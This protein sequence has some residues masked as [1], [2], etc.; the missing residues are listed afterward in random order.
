MIQQK[1]VRYQ[2]IIKLRIKTERT[3]PTAVLIETQSL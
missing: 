2:N 3:H 1:N